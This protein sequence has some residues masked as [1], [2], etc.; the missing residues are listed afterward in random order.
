MSCARHKVDRV[1]VVGLK[2][3]IIILKNTKIVNM[4]N[5][6]LCLE[7]NDILSITS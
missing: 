3:T 2:V 5:W 7:K 1:E 6:G 4:G